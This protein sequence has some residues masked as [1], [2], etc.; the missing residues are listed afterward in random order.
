MFVFWNSI[1]STDVIT[2]SEA[3]VYNH[4]SRLKINVSELFDLEINFTDIYL[5][6]FSLSLSITIL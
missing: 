1:Q 2:K 5:L 3:I 6:R 4:Y